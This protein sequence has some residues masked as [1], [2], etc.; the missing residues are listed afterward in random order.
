MNR[1]K[2]PKECHKCKATSNDFTD[3]SGFARHLKSHEESVQCV[4]CGLNIKYSR[5][6]QSHIK[7]VHENNRR[8][9]VTYAMIHFQLNIT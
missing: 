2:P 7:T 5:V 1:G 3:S 4:E 9:L 6:L 8:F